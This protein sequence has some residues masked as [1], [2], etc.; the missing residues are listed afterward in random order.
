MNLQAR[1]RTRTVPVWLSLLLG[2]GFLFSGVLGIAALSHPFTWKWFAAAAG[3]LSAVAFYMHQATSGRVR[4]L[5]VTADGVAIDGEPVPRAQLRAG[6]YVPRVAGRASH[7]VLQRVHGDPIEIDIDGEEHGRELLATLGLDADRQAVTFTLMGPYPPVADRYVQLAI[8]FGALFAVGAA[9]LAPAAL[10]LFYLTLPVAVR[11]R[12]TEVHVGTDGV[13]VRR[14]LG[15]TFI[16]AD[17]LQGVA[18]RER[19]VVLL[20]SDGPIVIAERDGGKESLA[21]MQD[22]EGVAALAARV[23]AVVQARDTAI[24]SDAARVL[25]RGRSPLRA[26]LA[27]LAT[28]D[29]DAYRSAGLATD[30]LAQVL[31]R[32]PSRWARLGA[33][34]L[35]ARRK[36]ELPRIRIAAEACAE[37][38]L[39]VALEG[40]A[41][42]ASEAEVERALAEIEEEAEREADEQRAAG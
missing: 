12:R 15:S 17:R 38:K 13:L 4:Q 19:E 36:T 18:D 22:R 14:L 30:E 9:L 37:P 24:A 41:S 27:S 26:W 3:T 2:F 1:T 8:V 35:L 32:S 21:T 34:V 42:A 10:A 23:R 7:V 33:A 16:P 6:F 39:R 31:E 11:L 40:I 25:E 5:H 28:R 20:T 29:G